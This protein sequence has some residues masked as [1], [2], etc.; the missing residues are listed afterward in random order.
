MNYTITE[1]NRNF[2]I[3]VAG[4]QGG[5]KINRLYGVSGLVALIGYDMAASIINKAFECM[6]DVYTHRLRRG[7]KISLYVH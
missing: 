4:V 5:E 3:K 7:L 2:L 6:D 1:I